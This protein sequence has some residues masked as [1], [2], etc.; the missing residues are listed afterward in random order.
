[1]IIKNVCLVNWMNFYH[2]HCFEFKR[3]F[4]LVIG[5]GMSG[6]TNL[7]RA[8]KFAFLGQTDVR[9]SDLIN[10][11]HK[12]ESLKENG[13]AF[14][15]VEVTVELNGRT[16]I[17]KSELF[18]TSDGVIIQTTSVPSQIDSLMTPKNFMLIY[19]EPINLY[20]VKC[21]VE[22][23][24]FSERLI[25]AMEKRLSENSKKGLKIAIFDNV[26]GLLPKIKAEE[27]LKFIK[28]MSLEQAIFMEKLL[29]QSN[30][31]IKDIEKWQIN[32]N[33]KT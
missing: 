16:Y 32:L 10:H 20:E 33:H 14:C 30:P 17:A 18:L 22:Q 15:K 27:F 13:N 19:L 3:G 5:S 29:E 11:A 25:D 31:L 4:N 28:K 26:F 24:T 1:M 23:R 2:E 8:L 12:Q 7:T 21:I 9:R 6:K